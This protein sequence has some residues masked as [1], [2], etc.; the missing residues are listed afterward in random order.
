MP[1]VVHCDVLK[2]KFVEG[3]L[4][5]YY[6]FVISSSIA[7]TSE[8]LSKYH[9]ELGGIDVFRKWFEYFMQVGKVSVVNRSGYTYKEPDDIDVEYLVASFH[10]G[11]SCVVKDGLKKEDKDLFWKYGVE[12]T[13]V[14][15][16]VK[17]YQDEPIE[18]LSF[19][20][21]K[22]VRVELF[23]RY[24]KQE[25]NIFIYDRFF[26][27]TALAFVEDM[28]GEMSK[29]ATVFVATGNDRCNVDSGEIKRK[30]ENLPNISKATV[31]KVDRQCERSNHDRFAFFG[32]R[33]YVRGTAGFDSFEKNANKWNTRSCEFNVYYSSFCKNEISFTFEH[34]TPR[35]FKIK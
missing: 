16:V 35:R 2:G 34:G 30:L 28:C 26:N 22:N 4:E 20:N 31:K 19:Y 23:R 11:L 27:S 10:G 1:A 24:F 18:V 14:N 15:D 32:S 29:G 33:Y 25:K 9:E 7:A 13:Y 6:D 5:P 12:C 3:S 21:E 17:A 8:L